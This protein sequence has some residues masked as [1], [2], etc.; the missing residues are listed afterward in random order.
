M[1]EVDWICAAVWAALL[2]AAWVVQGP[3]TRVGDDEP[4]DNP[5]ET[6]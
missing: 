2:T 6:T 5:H 3:G 4:S 1:D